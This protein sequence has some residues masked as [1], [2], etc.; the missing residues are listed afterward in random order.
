MCIILAG[1]GKIRA[2]FGALGF[3][4]PPPAE[5]ETIEQFVTRHLGELPQLIE[6]SL[7]C[8]N[9]VR[10]NIVALQATR[11]SRRSLTPSCQVFTRVI[12]R[13]YR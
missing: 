13:N 7:D 8:V 3:V 11:R 6:A 9:N 12:P 1:P 2:G 5:E 10:Q 4:A